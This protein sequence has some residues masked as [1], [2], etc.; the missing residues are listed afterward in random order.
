VAGLLDDLC[1]YAARDDHPALVQ[2]ALVHA[3]F[4]TIHPFADGNGRTGRALIHVVLRRRGLAPRFVPPI[5]LILATHADAYVKALTAYR[6][7]G[8]AD[9][10]AASEGTRAWFALFAADMARACADTVRFADQLTD[11]EHQWRRKVGRVRR[12][13]SVDLLLGVL[14]AAPVLTVATAS[15]LIGRSL[16]KSNEAVARLVDAGVLTQTSIGR[17]NRAF[18]ARI[19]AK[20]EC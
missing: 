12:G 15:E 11:L 1:A 13:S 5:S 6:H 8:L 10:A 7:P 3:Q 20:L 16:Q 2:A 9:S 14:P 18:E 19:S 17:R 4:E